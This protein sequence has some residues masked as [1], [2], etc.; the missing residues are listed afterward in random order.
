FYVGTAWHGQ[1]LARALMD[2]TVARA[3]L[4][5]HDAIWLSV[6]KHN[7]RARRF[8]EKCGFVAVGEVP[9]VFGGEAEL[10]TLMVLTIAGAV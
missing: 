4:T 2:A 3:A 6:W 10:D 9:F 8:Y 1:G 7:A 5:G